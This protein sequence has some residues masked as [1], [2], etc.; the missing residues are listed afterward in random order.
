MGFQNI[1]QLFADTGVSTDQN[2][3]CIVRV[4][5]GYVQHHPLGHQEWSSA[6]GARIHHVT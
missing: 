1:E 3:K 4:P 6:K 2:H 5:S